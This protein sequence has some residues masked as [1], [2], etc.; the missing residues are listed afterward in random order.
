MMR[1]SEIARRVRALWQRSRIA[2]DLDEEM[3]LHLEL[4]QKRLQEG[5]VTADAAE[6][7][8]RRRFG[9]PLHVRE[10]AMDAWGWRWL[11]Q[12]GQDARFG[13]R[14]LARNPGFALAAIGTL[15]LGI[16]ANTAV[17]S[18]VSGVVLRPLPFAAPDRLVRIYG[19]SR[20]NP[21]GEA[22]SNVEEFRR[23]NQLFEGIAGAEVTAR[24]LR[25][26]AGPERVM[27]VTAERDFFAILGVPPLRGRTFTR[28]D[29]ADVAVIGESFWNARLGGSP[30]V[31][32]SSLDIDSHR[33][34]II[35]VMPASFQFPY[36][37]A[38]LLTGVAAEGRTDLWIPL[39]PPVGPRSRIG[40]V[41]GR[42]RPNV[43][44][45]AAQGELA[46]I[47]RQL[48]TQYPETNQGRGVHV[49]PLS[50]AVVS[51]EVRRPLFVLFGAV[52]LLL[53]LACSNVANLLLVRL[54]LR[55]REVAVRRALGASRVRLL[56]QFL[57]ESLLLSSAGGLV[58]LGLGWWGT[59]SLIQIA[60]AQIP[61]AREVSLDW[62]V[63]LFL[64]A[65]CTL[66][67]FGLSL[68]P[69]LA[70]GR[71]DPRSILQ[72]S[73]GHSTMGTRSRRLRDG[74]V[75]AEVALAFILAVGAALLIRELVRLRNT[76]SGMITKN[77]V[78][79]HVGHRMT[80][81]TDVRQF[82]EMSDRVEQLP[83]VRAAGFTQLLPLQNW[84][85]TSNSSDFQVRG[86]PPEPT[87]FPI[88]LRFVTPGYFRAL[89][90]P[91]RGRAFTN[92][93]DRNTMRVILINE[94]LARK[95]FPGEDALGKETGRGRI[96]GIVG[97]VRQANLDRPSVPELYTP[98]AQNWSQLSELGLTL[99]VSTYNRPEQ[100]IEPVRA[101]VHDIN[102]NQAIFRIK[103]MDDVVAESLSD[104]TVY[105]S[106]IA[107]AAG[108][109]LVL[110][111]TGTY[112]V[113]SHI[114]T[115][116]TREFA[117]RVALGADRWRVIRLVIG[118]GA[119]LALVGLG[120]GVFGAFA[121]G[122]VL[123][124][125][126]VSVRPPDLVT[127]APIA[128][129]IASVAILACLAPARRAAV[130]DPIGALRSE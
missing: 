55:S 79:F 104:F 45:G 72:E 64:V 97:D 77:V 111:S 27:A 71:R 93:D 108:L 67:G 57:T 129:L 113:I 96:V 98:I 82:Y 34:T 31:I 122:R 126:P 46:A 61:R 7:A 23:R 115:A 15:A 11:E 3:A 63:F 123:Q 6:I 112:A 106:L 83:G 54:T 14:T 2:Q 39:N 51:S 47:A 84:G 12:L 16:G 60:G 50:R 13:L 36:R 56:R 118:Q 101:V 18:V 35:G 116:R 66:I 65:V 5:S 21:S 43:P 30:S 110:A 24:Y 73:G 78:T 103:T 117:I 1:P 59:K 44:L 114:A 29:P 91:V 100:I 38:S 42:L 120:V 76:D 74:L 40:G 107:S 109:A 37:A 49:V 62:R 89:G 127:V 17:F 92:Q 119:R 88:E 81:A 9:D 121:G 68:A 75:V 20:L 90:I 48:E 94:T 102:P 25:G 95:S 85:W 41:I 130:K 19:T 4:R 32:G 53:A 124:G 33:F 28:D 52:C 80:P 87:V 99:V 105:L 10:D 58:G 8:A 125:L 70:F 22:L 128:V 86:R 26:A 69:A